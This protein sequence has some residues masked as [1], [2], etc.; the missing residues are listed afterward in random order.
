VNQELIS[1]ALPTR[2]KQALLNVP[3]AFGHTWESCYAMHL[4]TGFQTFLYQ[5]EDNDVKV[6]CPIAERDYMGYVDIVTPYG[7]SGFVG[8]GDFLGFQ[9][10]WKTFI[11]ELGYVCGFI[12]LN[13]L[14]SNETY[15][16]KREVY[17]YNKLYVINLELTLDEL[18][19]KLSLN[20]KRQLKLYKDLK[21]KF[22]V[23]KVILKNFF[24][25]HYHAF[26]SQRNASQVYNFTLDTLSYLLDLKNVFVVGICHNE[27]I[28]AVSVF[29]YT[30]YGAEYLFNV[31]Q[32][33]GRHYTVPL[34][35][36][37]INYLKSL[38]IPYLNLGGGVKEGDSIAQFKKRFGAEELPLTC[39]KQVYNFKIYNML[40]QK[41]NRNPDNWEGYFPAYRQP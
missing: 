4:T 8:N 19:H 3:H 22:I 21:D 16:N 11:H 39:L 12:G 38:R 1:L 31:S 27:N 10:H 28:E 23:D 2:W 25:N 35:W 5:F 15:L 37:A 29:A 26:F 32:P 6:V 40:C 14:F 9:S 30:P 17:Q 13:P 24:L 7:F 33:V 20:R 41:T 18:F 34:I 36:Y